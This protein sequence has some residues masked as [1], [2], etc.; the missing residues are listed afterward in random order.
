MPE[1]TVFTLADA[2]DKH[3]VDLISLY[4]EPDDDTK[5]TLGLDAATGFGSDFTS[6]QVFSNRMPF[7]QVAW[8][9]NKR[10]TTV[11]GSEVMIALARYYNDAFIVPETRHPGNAYVDNAIEV[12]GYGNIYRRKQV[13]DE[14][15]TVSTKYGICTTEGD[16]H[17]LINN[18]KA[19][20]EN[21]DGPQVIFHDPITLNEFCNFVYIEDK[22]KT[23]AGEG[24]HDDTVIAAMLALYGCSMWPQ[25]AR[26]VE[27]IYD[28]A[29]E[30][31][32]H[33][34]YLMMQDRGRMTD[35]KVELVKV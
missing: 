27:E 32:A 35:G 11:K 4:A 33:Q 16:K 21:R 30:D 31:K 25:A 6:M 2:N 18:A 19:L 20:M 24:F 12:Y 1:R 26:E 23:G 34:L 7:E 9:R 28:A 3:R 14:D 10:V 13:L 15:P 17:L 22:S 5:Y 29:T 8:V